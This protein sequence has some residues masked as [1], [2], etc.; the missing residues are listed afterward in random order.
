MDAD[1][2]HLRWLNSD[3][4]FHQEQTNPYLKRFWA[5]IDLPPGGK[6]LVPLAG[7]SIDM[8]W[9]AK[10]GYNVMGVEISPVAVAE[11]FRER[12]VSAGRWQDGPFEV[13]MDRKIRL[14]C[15]DFFQ[16]DQRR[17]AD[18]DAVYDRAALIAFPEA[19][20]RDYVR[21][22]LENLPGHASQLLITLEYDQDEMNGPPFSVFEDEVRELYQDAYAIDVLA[23]DDVWAE[24]PRFRDKGLTW[25]QEKVYRLT[26]RGAG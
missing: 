2:W 23:D 13:W 16:L 22:M 9:L 3:I 4:A 11:F 12:G 14:L 17:L 5:E 10:Q 26:P 20:R 1:F 7:K 15:G 25:L 21:H 8:L 19:M 6:V 18:I 24:T